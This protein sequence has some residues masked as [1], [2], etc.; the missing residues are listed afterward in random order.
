MSTF[1]R[2]NQMKEEGLSDNQIIQTLR[3]EGISPKEID[4]SLSQS[5]IKDEITSKNMG[6][7]DQGFAQENNP[8]YARSNFE[9]KNLSS[10]FVAPMPGDMQPIESSGQEYYPEYT[11]EGQEYAQAPAF[12]IETIN[13]M[14]D[15]S[16][17]E[18]NDSIKKQ[19]ASFVKFQEN[20]SIELEKINTRLQKIEEIIS[21]LQI[22]IIRKVGQY[23]QD[24]NT[25]AREMGE[26]QKTF[27]KI[28][29]PLTDNIRELRNLTNN[30]SPKQ[31]AEIENREIQ[32]NSED[33][34]RQNRQKERDNFENFL[35]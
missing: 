29:D 25:I 28:I 1:E 24:I 35:R 8:E 33:T 3:Q 19:V 2:V 6:Y 31:K 14:I 17:E 23:G 22:S 7:Q 32:K 10:E 4:E 21:E 16:I 20:S 26:T 13:E 34:N 27:S 11:P 5:K 12:D 18:K 15:Q 30:L 9:D